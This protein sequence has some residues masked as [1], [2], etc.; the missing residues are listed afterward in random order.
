[1]YKYSVILFVGLVA[2]AAIA[3]DGPEDST[4]PQIVV[5]AQWKAVQAGEEPEPTTRDGSDLQ[6]CLQKLR[7][8]C[9]ALA[10]EQETSHQAER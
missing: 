4:I 6:S 9:E 8:E 3:S 7:A 5:P 10:T 2:S 1:M